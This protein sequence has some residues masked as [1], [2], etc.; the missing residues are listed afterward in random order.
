M[1]TLIEDGNGTYHGELRLDDLNVRASATPRGEVTREPEPFTQV[2]FEPGET[3][4]RVVVL[5]GKNARERDC[6][7]QWSMKGDHPLS[8]GVFVGPTFLNVEGPLTGSAYR[9]GTAQRSVR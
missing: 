8:R 6:T 4:E 7:A 9:L 2:F 5:A 3:V 1:V